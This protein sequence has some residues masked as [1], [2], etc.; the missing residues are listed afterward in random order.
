MTDP[1]K[2]SLWKQFGFTG[3]DTGDYINQ[4]S[5]NLGFGQYQDTESFHRQIFNKFD[6][7]GSGTIDAAELTAVLTQCGISV[8][9]ETV[10]GM[11]KEI[12]QDANNQLDFNEF[13]RLIRKIQSGNMAYVGVT[14]AERGPGSPNPPVVDQNLLTPVGQNINNFSAFNNGQFEQLI[15]SLKAHDGS[16]GGISCAEDINAAI[17]GSSGQI[18]AALRQKLAG[19]AG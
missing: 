11:L 5:S 7:D 14:T 9:Q 17:A 8:S 10:N 1:V 12:D 2:E 3:T 19:I 4:F 16:A 13:L 15:N 6:R 18:E